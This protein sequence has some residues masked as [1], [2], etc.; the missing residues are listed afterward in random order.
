MCVFG[1]ATVYSV[2]LKILPA[3][4][5]VRHDTEQSDDHWCMYKED[6]ILHSV[7]HS[8]LVPESLSVRETLWTR[9][10]LSGREGGGCIGHRGAYYHSFCTWK[11]RSAFCPIN[12]QVVLDSTNEINNPSWAFFLSGILCLYILFYI[13]TV[14]SFLFQQIKSGEIRGTKG[15]D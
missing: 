9:E 2:L 3:R 1:Q 4:P 6:S 5:N 10:L 12:S 15:E 14:Y 13:L 8:Y 7:C 11:W